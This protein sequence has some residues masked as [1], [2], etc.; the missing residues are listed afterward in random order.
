MA[1]LYER[2]RQKGDGSLVRARLRLRL[3][4]HRDIP[5]PVALGLLLPRDSTLATSTAKGPA[6]RSAASSPTP[7]PTGSSP[8]SPSGS[9]RPTSQMLATYSIAYR[10]PYLSDC[11]QP[12]VLAEAVYAASRGEGGA[13]SWTRSCPGRA[14]SSTGWTACAIRTV[15]ASS[16]PSSPTSRGSTT[17]RSTTPTS[18][19]TGSTPS[20]FTAAWQRVAG[21]YARPGSRSPRAM[22]ALDRFVME[23]VLVNTIYGRERAGPRPASC[24]KEDDAEGALE[25][26]RP[27]ATDDGTPS[28]RS[29]GMPTRG[30]F[31]DLAGLR[32][33]AAARQYGVVAHAARARRTFRGRWP[34]ALVSHIEDP[35]EYRRSLPRPFGRDG[36]AVLPEG[37]GRGARS[38]GADRPGSTPTGTSRAGSGATAA[39][40][41]PVRSRTARPPSWSRAA[42]AS[43]T[44]RSPGEGFGAEHFSWTAWSSTCSPR[45]RD[46]VRVINE[47]VPACRRPRPAPSSPSRDTASAKQVL[48]L[49]Y[50]PRT[51]RA[52]ATSTFPWMCPRARLDSTCRTP[53]TSSAAQNVVDLGL[54][55]PGPLDHG[56][57]RAPGWTGGERSGS[58][59]PREA[60]RRATGRA[61]FRRTMARPARAYTRSRAAGVD[62]ELTFET[63]SRPPSPQRRR[64]LPGREPLAIGPALVPRRPPHPHR[65]QRRQA[66]GGRAVRPRARRGW[67]SSPSPTTTTPRTRPTASATMRS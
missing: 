65:P 51:G 5:L 25:L 40:T 48:R 20:E 66:D 45:P 64:L 53:T 7:C 9:E 23:D 46:D 61:L 1:A 55:E 27:G 19:S 42:S 18:G 59:S 62:I 28:G 24:G 41:W 26:D 63:R 47:D 58:R 49:H 52:A 67:S 56:Q 54:F 8:T 16:R 21:P 4:V 57:A 36:R 10:T 3:P 2:N 38:S 50:D 6:P 43:T 31:F 13:P 11:M 60:P 17:R 39:K 15:T 34:D 33:G 37:P 30:L 29:A 12:P 44:I 14:G 32:R 35:R 22:F